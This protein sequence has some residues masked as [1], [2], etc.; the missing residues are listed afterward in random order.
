MPRTTLRVAAGLTL[1]AGLASAATPAL[2]DPSSEDAGVVQA[3]AIS[4]PAVVSFVDE[5]A[6]PSPQPVL[7]ELADRI[8]ADVAAAE[9][10]AALQRLAAAEEAAKLER[11]AAAVAAE[12]ARRAEEARLAAQQAATSTA[13]AGSVEE[14]IHRWFG[15]SGAKAVQVARCE[16][17][18]NPGAV[19]AGGGNHGLFQINNVHRG[20]FE[21]VTGQPWSAVYSAEANTRFAHWLWSQQGWGPWACA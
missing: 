17:G 7:Q 1:A 3:A 6:V 2:G 16:S 11:F 8:A 9:E 5:A 20:T 18:L 4:E 10:A 13:P 21:S 19:S 12:E 14:I 15:A